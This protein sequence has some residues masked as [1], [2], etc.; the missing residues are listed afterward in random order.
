M[1]LDFEHFNSEEAIITIESALIAQRLELANAIKASA[2]P[3]AYLLQGD[4]Q[5]NHTDTSATW[6]VLIRK[7]NGWLIVSDSFVTPN[8]KTTIKDSSAMKLLSTIPKE[9]CHEIFISTEAMANLFSS[10]LKAYN[11]DIVSNRQKGGRPPKYNEDDKK[12]I[13]ELKAQGMSNRAIARQENM[14]PTTVAKLMKEY[15]FA[16]IFSNEV[17]DNE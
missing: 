17:Q 14:S 9:Q 12:R 3:Y 4:K 2:L 1:K 10:L 8:Q 15:E 13:V 5:S 16:Q 11:V 7:D 6:I